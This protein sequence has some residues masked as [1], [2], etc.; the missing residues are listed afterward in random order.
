MRGRGARL[1][2]GTALRF[3]LCR[4]HFFCQ[5][6]IHGAQVIGS[7]KRILAQQRAELR[8]G[9]P[10]LPLIDFFAGAIGE[11]THAFR[12][13]PRSISATF[14]QTR[15]AALA[16]PVHCFGCRLVN[17]HDIVAVQ[18]HAWQAISRRSV[19]YAWGCRPNTA[20]GTSVAYW[21]FSQTNS[22][23]SFQMAAR[24]NPS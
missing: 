4:G 14:E 24:F 11:I 13:G 19:G 18:L 3:A 20:N 8:D 9:A 7:R 6:S 2:P 23:G 10:A 12:M 22:T 1:G 17:G 16:S 15:P 5:S 21:L